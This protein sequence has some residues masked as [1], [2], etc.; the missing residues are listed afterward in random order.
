MENPIGKYLD[1]Y[2]ALENSA[3][4]PVLHQI[5]RSYP[6]FTLGRYMYLRALA[7]T[8]PGAYHRARNNARVQMF[9]HPYPRI[10]L[11]SERRAT[12]MSDTD[13]RS[14][15]PANFG[16]VCPATQQLPEHAEPSIIIIDRFLDKNVTRITPPPQ[17]TPH[18]DISQHSVAEDEQDNLASETLAEIYLAQGLPDKAIA[19]YS[20]LSLIYPEKSDYFA[21]RISLVRDYYH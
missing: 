13:I 15:L 12:V 4:L 7:T 18:E 20:K 3:A 21:D 5:V 14:L 16:A 2:A 9:T 8:E 6:W 10:L 1:D 11:A 17:D 19:V